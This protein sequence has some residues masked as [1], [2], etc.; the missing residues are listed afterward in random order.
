[1]LWYQFLGVKK[2]ILFSH[3][4]HTYVRCL[5]H[6]TTVKICLTFTCHW[7]EQ[8][9]LWCLACYIYNKLF[10]CL[11]CLCHEI[12]EIL[13]HEEL[14]IWQKIIA[15]SHTLPH[16]IPTYCWRPT[17]ILCGNYVPTLVLPWQ[18]KDKK[19]IHRCFIDVKLS[20]VGPTMFKSP[21]YRD[22]I[23]CLS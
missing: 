2:I 14:S 20:L 22:R 10:I 21:S 11:H 23:W 16:C 4:Y 19:I 6:R 13:N 17:T 3:M 5:S 9:S 12:D 18:R 7:I 15:L 1:M 8:P